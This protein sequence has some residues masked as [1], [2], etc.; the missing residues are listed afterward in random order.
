[1]NK[2]N[3]KIPP[4]TR[5][6]LIFPHEI[7]GKGHGLR[8]PSLILT[9]SLFHRF[10]DRYIPGYVFFADGIRSGFHAD[11]NCSFPG[12]DRGHDHNNHSHDHDHQHHHRHGDSS[13]TARRASTE[14]EP[15]HPDP[16]RPNDFD[17]SNFNSNAHGSSRSSGTTT[18]TTTTTSV[19]DPPWKGRGLCIR[20][21]AHRAV[22]G[23]ETF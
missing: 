23:T 20:L 8:S 17:N 5:C 13:E 11:A 18:T 12:C 4:S 9:H 3:C 7:L 15:Q 22:T 21:D 16:G 1:M 10:I 6:D 14:N 19:A 2:S